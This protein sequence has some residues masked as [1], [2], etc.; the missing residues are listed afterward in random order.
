MV[1]RY[2]PEGVDSM[3][4]IWYEPLL[5]AMR[6]HIEEKHMMEDGALDELRFTEEFLSYGEFSDDEK[7]R[8]N[9]PWSDHCKCDWEIEGHITFKLE[10]IQ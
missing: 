10:R 9:C 6:H 8:L 3:K 4:Y 1:R 2:R 5:E 7:V